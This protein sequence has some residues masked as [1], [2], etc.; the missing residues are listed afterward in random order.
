MFIHFTFSLWK[1]TLDSWDCPVIMII[2]CYFQQFYAYT[3]YFVI[4]Q[5]FHTQF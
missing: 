2:L 4:A 5:L 3:M 1:L